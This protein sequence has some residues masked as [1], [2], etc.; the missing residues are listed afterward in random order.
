LPPVCGNDET[1]IIFSPLAAAGASVAAAA[2]AS[3]ATETAG[4]VPLH[5]VRSPPRKASIAIR[6]RIGFIALLC[7]LL[8][9]SVCVESALADEFINIKNACLLGIMMMRYG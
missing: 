5:A 4:G 1:M 6:L 7:Y 9:R 2:G 3:V 8:I